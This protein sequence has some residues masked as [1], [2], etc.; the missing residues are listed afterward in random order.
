M[1]LTD[2]RQIHGN[3]LNFRQIF[4]PDLLSVCQQTSLTADRHVHISV[5]DK[6]E[7]KSKLL[8]I[9]NKL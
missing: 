3:N 1:R 2:L 6:P 4:Q 8:I 9:Y 5:S 7:H